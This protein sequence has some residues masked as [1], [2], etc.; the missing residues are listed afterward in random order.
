MCTN[1]G[2]VPHQLSLQPSEKCPQV[3]PSLAGHNIHPGALTSKEARQERSQH[4]SHARPQ[5]PPAAGLRHCCCSGSEL[6][7]L[8]PATKGR[9]R[10]QQGAEDRAGVWASG[11][12]RKA[13]THQLGALE[14]GPH[15]GT[16]ELKLMAWGKAGRSGPR[17]S[18]LTPHPLTIY[19]QHLSTLRPPQAP[20]HPKPPQPKPPLP[21]TF[22]TLDVQLRFP[23]Q[24][25][26]NRKATSVLLWQGSRNHSESQVR[27]AHSKPSRTGVCTRMRRNA[28]GFLSPVPVSEF[29]AAPAPSPRKRSGNSS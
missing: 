11:M 24:I 12:R 7:A 10:P 1:T 15:P 27:A 19:P 4:G 2:L 9:E 23:A 8:G 25:L 21:K 13:R 3:Q 18:H 6:G 22:P 26:Q 14:R 17:A 16:P 28:C 5:A 20:S 29:E